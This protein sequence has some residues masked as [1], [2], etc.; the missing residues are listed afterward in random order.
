MD[1]S[2]TRILVAVILILLLAAFGSVFIVAVCHSDSKIDDDSLLEEHGAEAT[3]PVF[4]AELAEIT[5]GITR[6]F[7]KEDMIDSS[8]F[9]YVSKTLKEVCRMTNNTHRL[10]VARHIAG[11]LLALNLTNGSYRIRDMR[12]CEAIGSIPYIYETLLDANAP[13]E[14]R[15][16]FLFD[17]LQH[18]KDGALSTLGGLRAQM[19]EGKT[20]DGKIALDQDGKP[21]KFYPSADRSNCARRIE[22][23]LQSQ[24][25]YLNN[26]VFRF[27]YPKLSP[28]T[29]K[30][31]KKRFREVF[32]ID[33]IP[34]EPRKKAHIFGE[35]G[36]IWD[37]KGLKWRIC[38]ENDNWHDVEAVPSLPEPV[39]PLAEVETNVVFSAGAA[40][41]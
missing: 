21:L 20:A 9:P 14:E 33:Y 37:G 28:D 27:M 11:E 13:E 30:Y 18:F 15:C 31:F 36:T 16:D 2:T 7:H 38:D 5:N 35:K 1:K 3:M 19:V 39:R 6:A 4:A 41:L 40:T 32:G 29:Q 25:N 10:V 22:S 24:P 12:I 8:V 34:D 17:A 26:G 23:S